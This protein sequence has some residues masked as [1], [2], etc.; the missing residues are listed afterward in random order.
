MAWQEILLRLGAAAVIDAV[1]ALDRE[2]RHKV[3]GRVANAA[4]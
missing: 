3:A 4:D 1:I 2:L